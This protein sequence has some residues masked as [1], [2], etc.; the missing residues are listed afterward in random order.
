MSLTGSVEGGGLLQHP[1]FAPVLL[2]GLSIA[3]TWPAAISP[4]WVGRH[5]DTLGTLWVIDAAPRLLRDGMHDAHTAW[6]T[7]VD[8]QRPDSML[9]LLISTAV[10]WMQPANVLS[11][12]QVGGLAISAWAAEACARV[13]GAERPW[14]IIAGLAFMFGGLGSTALLEGHVYAVFDPWLPLT[15]GAG[16]RA[17]QADGRAVHGLIAGVGFLLCLLTSAY[18]G[19]AALG[20]LAALL[21]LAVLERRAK[22]GVALRPLLALLGVGLPVSLVYA[23]CF[24][25]AAGPWSSEAALGFMQAPATL[26]NLLGPNDTIDDVYHSLVTAVPPTTLA[27][28][29]LAPVLLVQQHGWR[30]VAGAGLT[31]LVLSMG[32]TLD[33][34]TADPLFPL[35][36]SLLRFIPGFGFLHFPA[37]LGWAWGLCLGVVAARVAGALAARQRAAGPVL[38]LMLLVDLFGLMALPMRQHSQSSSVPTAYTAADGPLL[39]LFPTDVTRTR[40]L[41]LAF[42]TLSCAYQTSHHRPIAEVCITTS[43]WV[44]PRALLGRWIYDE[45]R[46]G[47]DFAGPLAEM[48]FATVVLHVDLFRPEDRRVIEEALARMDYAPTVSVDGGEHL[49]AYQIPPHPGA[50]PAEAWAAWVAATGA[51]WG[52]ATAAE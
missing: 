48:G 25:Q 17:A 13:L 5:S 8:Y 32:S 7:G 9:L 29:L 45:A 46:A 39:D 14:S 49:V 38:A 37:R 47:G 51:D 27:L 33:I 19:L 30:S 15:L 11:A 44:S 1:A 20:M 4:D 43:P 16:W 28:F 2:L 36:L 34:S 12:F 40:R 23:W 18:V 22:G 52:A 31:C 35:P 26:V 50:Q 41:E 21:P 10:G 42:M 6:P 3:W 24:A